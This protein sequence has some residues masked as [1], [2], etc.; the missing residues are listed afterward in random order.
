LSIP[1]TKE[2]EGRDRFTV[3]LAQIAELSRTS[4]PSQVKRY[5][6]QRE[7]RVTGSVVDRPAGDVRAD[8]MLALDSLD[9]LPGYSI[10]AVGEAEIQEESFS[11]IFIALFLAV[12]FIYLILASQY[13]SFSDP[14]SIMGALPLAI[15]GALIS[16]W[17]FGSALSIMSLIGVVLLM[18]LVTKNG[19][20][21]I[22]F[23]KQR[24]R[25]GMGR[26]EALLEAGPIR[27]RPILMTSFST[28]AGALPLALAIGEG[29]EF[30]API[31]RAVIGGMIS[32]T[33]LTLLVVPVIYSYVDD[34]AHGNFRAIFGLTKKP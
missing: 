23:A 13:D 30:R 31:A 17:I 12:L 6:R 10:R 16:L 15:I 18:G 2:I 24:R 34:L 1:S 22:D 32:S 28:I 20:L 7:I 3:P 25:H 9:L 11:N 21:L 19:I 8:I 14:L 29:A 26:D 4:G 5:D 33:V 27:L